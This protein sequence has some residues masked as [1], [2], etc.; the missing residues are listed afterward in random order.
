MKCFFIS[1]KQACND[2]SYYDNGHFTEDK[3]VTFANFVDQFAFAMWQC[4]H[5]DFQIK[6]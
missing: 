5:P 1:G 3:S 6:N 4:G 2:E